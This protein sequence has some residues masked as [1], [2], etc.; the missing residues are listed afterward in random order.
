MRVVGYARASLDCD[1]H[2]YLSPREQH[3]MLANWARENGHRLVAV[4]TDE[5]ETAAAA[6]GTRLALG[7]ALDLVRSEK[8]GA[9]LVVRLE[10]LSPEILTQELLRAE[11]ARMGARLL[12]TLAD[13][14]AELSDSPQSG[15]RRLIREV[16]GALPAHDEAMRDLWVRRRVGKLPPT[17]DG[18][19]AALARI[20]QLADQGMQARDIARTLSAEGFRPRL[21]HVFD[22]AGLRR[23][24][25]RSR[26]V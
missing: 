18:E 7:D 13:E 2:E 21:A 24:V 26:V 14:E 19:E 20:E 9:L 22:L 11:A 25:T 12:S 15:E 16:L 3:D 10:R 17:D 4:L 6:L 5:G 8:A 1:V 23:I